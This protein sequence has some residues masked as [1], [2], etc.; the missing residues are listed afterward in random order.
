MGRVLE[1]GSRR[2]D[3]PDIF[4][5]HRALDKPFVR[6]LSTDLAALGVDVWMDEWEVSPGDSLH[7]QIADALGG[8]KLVAIVIGPAGVTSEW[9][10]TEINAALTREKRARATLVVPIIHGTDEAPIPILLE[11]K[12]RL[13]MNDDR[14]YSGLVRLVAM[15]RGK[16][17]RDV[18]E[19]IADHEPES[20][21]DVVECLEDLSIESTVLLSKSQFEELL[22][23]GAYPSENSETEIYFDPRKVMRSSAISAPLRRLLK[24]YERYGRVQ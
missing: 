21:F 23:I 19:T 12:L 10:K 16:D 22:S 17:L 11:D 3:D 14:Y 5:S 18:A 15:V 8:S 2:V 4:M 6:T 20:I 1:R 9:M 7:G 24:R 13:E